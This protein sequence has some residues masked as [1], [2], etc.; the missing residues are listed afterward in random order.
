MRSP[1]VLFI[2]KR[3]KLYDDPSYAKTIQSGLYNSAH[4][5]YAMLLKHGVHANCVQVTDHNDIDREVARYRPDL[6][7]IEA[8]WVTPEKFTIL[9]RL[10]PKVKWVVRI[11]SEIPFIANE[12]IAMQWIHEYSSIAKDMN[13]WIA[14]NTK[15][16]TADLKSLGIKNTVTLPNY[17]PARMHEAAPH[18]KSDTIHIGCF[19]AIRPLKNQLI[20]AVAAIEYAN[21]I[22]KK[23]VF[24]I[25]SSRI[26]RG[27]TVI[28]N[29]RSLFGNHPTHT[30]VEHGWYNHSQF[31][32][33]IQQMDLGLQ[34][35][36]S[37]TFN[38]VAADFAACGVPVVGSKEI[39]WLHWLYKA[40]ATD[41]KSIV[42]H[43]FVADRGRK[44]GLQCL[45]HRRLVKASESAKIAWLK[46]L[47]HK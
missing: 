9:H 45:N 24:H 5:V 35:S 19:G 30:L 39:S 20:Q 16:M 6:V 33:L 40:D 17:Y 36:L 27:E 46:Y 10:H 14:P 15:K 38:I 42:N 18:K 34:V 32:L 11:H 29:I 8:L 26:E 43:L 7:I 47:D 21:Q 2:L 41:S 44:W 25:N 37:E 1:K 13:L 12:G 31:L 23:L 22:G 4:F 28:K 3:K